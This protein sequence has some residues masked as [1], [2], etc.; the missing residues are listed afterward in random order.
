MGTTCY[1]VQI[2]ENLGGSCPGQN[3]V[4]DGFTYYV[5]SVHP[6]GRSA[7]VANSYFR[8]QLIVQTSETIK[9]KTQ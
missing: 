5:E 3:I 1:E 7:I 8:L 4:I 9:G 6:T 2:R